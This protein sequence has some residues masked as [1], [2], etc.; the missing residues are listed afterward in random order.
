MFIIEPLLFRYLRFI[1]RIGRQGLSSACIEGFLS[2]SKNF[3]AVMDADHQHDEALL[4]L[5]LKKIQSEPKLDIVIGSRFIEGGGVGNWSKPR[6]TLSRLGKWVSSLILPENVSDPMSGFF[7]ARREFIWLLTPKLSGRGFKILLDILISAGETVRFAELPYQFRERQ[8]GESK[9]TIFVAA[10]FVALILEKLLGRVLPFRFICFIGVGAIGMLA[11]LTV[12][13]LMMALSTE[14]W[15]AQMLAAVSAMTVN[16]FLNNIFT[17]QDRQIAGFSVCRGLILFYSLCSGGFLIN[18]TI[19]TH[20]YQ[21]GGSWWL[22]GLAGG[23]VGAV[24]NYATNTSITWRN[25]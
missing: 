14:F 21:I 12:L 18:M 19:A 8:K 23:T 22:A 25:I 1:E 9:L 15:K 2:T 20:L 7:V 13:A 4:P 11:H 10:E 16:F 3:I 6:L 24:W 17:Y 5:L